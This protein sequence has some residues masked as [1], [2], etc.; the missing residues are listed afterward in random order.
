VEAEG[1]RLLVDCGLFEGSKELKQRNWKNLP[2]DPATIDWVLLNPRAHRSHRVPPAFGPRRFEG[3]NLCQRGHA[4][5]LPASASDSA[6]LQEEDAQ[7]AAKKGYSKPQSAL[8]ALHRDPGAGTHLIVFE[9]FR[10]LI[11]FAI[12][13]QFSVRSH[14][15][16]HILGSTW[17]ELTITEKG[18]QTL[19][20][21]SGDWGRYNQPILKDPEAPTRADFLLCESTYGTATIRRGR[22]RTSWQT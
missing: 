8:T 2:I 15:A 1:K 16:G 11:T 3:P 12:S 5:T 13:P 6:H 18:K 17:L 19:V 7:Y 10:A 4:R 20:V 22:W 21:F 9:R 14:D